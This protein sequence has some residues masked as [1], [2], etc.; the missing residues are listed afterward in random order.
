MP[1]LSGY[2][3]IIVA[4]TRQPSLWDSAASQ[5]SKMTRRRTKEFGARDSASCSPLTSRCGLGPSSRRRAA[6]R[7]PVF[8]R[9][10]LRRVC[11]DC[12]AC[13]HRLTG[14]SE[15]LPQV[16]ASRPQERRFGHSEPVPALPKQSE[17]VG[18]DADFHTLGSRDVSV[19]RRGMHAGPVTRP[20]GL[21]PGT[22]G[23]GANEQTS[24]RAPLRPLRLAAVQN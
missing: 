24:D 5:F 19:L 22:I 10:R 11:G 3:G 2:S 1:A 7:R 16:Q 21:L 12:R 17:L 20:P 9:L 13:W 8:H 6:V 18:G 14:G 15:L 23:A 4:R